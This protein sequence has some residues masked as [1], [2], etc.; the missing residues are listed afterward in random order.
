[1]RIPF[2]DTK[3]SPQDKILRRVCKYIPVVPLKLQQNRCH[4]GFQQILS[5]NAGKRGMPTDQSRS[6]PQLGSDR[7]LKF[8]L[9]TRT[10]RRLSVS[11]PFRRL[12]HSL[13]RYTPQ[14]LSLFYEIV[15]YIFRFNSSI[16]SMT[17]IG[18]S[19]HFPTCSPDLA[20][21][22]PAA[23]TRPRRLA[24]SSRILYLRI[25]PAA[26]MGKLSTNSMYLGTLCRA[27]EALM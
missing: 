10:N 20:V 24:A 9:P 4:F 21:S 7:L 19:G 13:C 12:R 5:L 14:I 11:N 22:M 25:F 23:P 15:N 3:N 6:D 17:R 8:M 2:G 1:M 26:F 27:R 18:G 16:F